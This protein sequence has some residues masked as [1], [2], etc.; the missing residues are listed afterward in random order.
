[1]T[2]RVGDFGLALGIMAI[3][4]CSARCSSTRSSPRFRAWPAETIAFF[5]M[6]FKASN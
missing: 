2:N 5:G 3:F 1:V 6:N 4:W